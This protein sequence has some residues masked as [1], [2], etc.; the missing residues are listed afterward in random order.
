MCAMSCA[1]H[2]SVI[3]ESC[4]SKKERKRRSGLFLKTEGTEDNLPFGA[5]GE[6]E[7]HLRNCKGISFGLSA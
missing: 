6:R 1:N 4:E 3:S 7:Q 5:S 2:V